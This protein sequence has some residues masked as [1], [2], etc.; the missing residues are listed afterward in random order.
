MGGVSYERL[1]LL[2][3]HDA[4]SHLCVSH[5]RLEHPMWKSTVYLVGIEGSVMVQAEAENK[6]QYGLSMLTRRLSRMIINE[7]VWYFENITYNEAHTSYFLLETQ[8]GLIRRLKWGVIKI[9]DTMSLKTGVCSQAPLM[10]A[11]TFGWWILVSML[12]PQLV[13][14]SFHRMNASAHCP[15]LSLA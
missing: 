12:H 5:P 15:A 9:Q 2:V 1:P 11:L 3:C 7:V 4:S 8:L 6:R 14:C 10:H 13:I